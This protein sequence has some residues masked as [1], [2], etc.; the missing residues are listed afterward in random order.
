MGIANYKWLIQISKLNV[1]PK[2]YL[3]RLA[4]SLNIGDESGHRLLEE[5]DE[6]VDLF[7][8]VLWEHD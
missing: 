2:I 6:M 7:G 8:G 1:D 4:E 3:F 5:F